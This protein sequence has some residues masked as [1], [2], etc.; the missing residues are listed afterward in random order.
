M[1][2]SKFALHAV[3]NYKCILLSQLQFEF[4]SLFGFKVKGS[5]FNTGK[6]RMFGFY[7][8]TK[9]NKPYFLKIQIYWINPKLLPTIQIKND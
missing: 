1:M 5:S 6:T 8:K 3:K 2:S 4:S 9:N 7:S